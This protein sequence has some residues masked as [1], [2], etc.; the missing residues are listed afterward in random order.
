LPGAL[1]Q[2]TGENATGAQQAGFQSMSSFLALMLNP[3]LDSRGGLANASAPG[4]AY[5]PTPALSPE[6]AAAYAAV[7]PRSGTSAQASVV[8]PA[9]FAGR[10]G[11]WGGGYGGQNTADG[12]A[13]FGS[14]NVTTRVGG[15]AAG[16]DYYLAPGT[17]VGLALAGGATSWSLASGLGSGKSEAIQFGFYGTQRFGAAY[18]SAAGAL[19]YHFMS[20]DRTV[21]VAGTDRLTAS[22]NAFN[23]GGRLETGYRFGLAG[24]GLTPY[25]ALQ[26]QVFR[27][28]SYSETASAGAGAFALNFDSRRVTTT[29][30][31]LGAWFDKAVALDSRA[32]L[33]LRSRVAWAHDSSSDPTVAAGFQTLPGSSFTVLG[34]KQPGSLAL[35]SLAGEIFTGRGWS[36]GAKFDGEFASGSRT[37]AGT[38]TARY[39]W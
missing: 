16:V 37:Y 8:R 1:T 23:A 29:R 11:V 28:P 3:T 22:F 2:L 34:A 26:A 27:A 20:T 13:A 36:F 31:E 30:V 21:T 14:A 32:I 39:T 35:L 18:F 24:F 4:L 38:G 12:D 17:V 6:A 15:I 5:A 25:A 10:Y 19:A 9:P 7:N 33:L